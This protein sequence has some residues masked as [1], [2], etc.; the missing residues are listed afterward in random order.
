MRISSTKR[1]KNLN[2]ETFEKAQDE[3]HGQTLQISRFF[4][5]VISTFL[6]NIWG[7]LPKENIL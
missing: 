1:Q 2:A 3:I 6:N 5:S 4:K 7:F